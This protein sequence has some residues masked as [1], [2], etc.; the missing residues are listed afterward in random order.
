MSEERFDRLESQLAQ[1]IQAI[2]TMQQ[3]MATKQDLALVGQEI[4]ALEQNMATKQDLALVRQEIAALQNNLNAL[5]EDVV[6]L[7]YRIDSVEGAVSIVIRNTFT[8]HQNFGI[9]IT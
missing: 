8:A 9:F 2:G 1:I 4:T 3:N 6:S 7:R 5:R